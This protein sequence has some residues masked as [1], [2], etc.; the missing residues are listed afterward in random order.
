MRLSASGV[1]FQ[2]PSETSDGSVLLAEVSP[3]AKGFAERSVE[4][5]WFASLRSCRTRL[6]WAWKRGSSWGVGPSCRG[7]FSMP[8]ML[9]RE[10]V[11]SYWSGDPYGWAGWPVIGL[12]AFFCWGLLARDALL[13][14]G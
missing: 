3:D 11:A 10:G 12:G 6:R 8:L 5:A 7:I 13:D 14:G 4:Y 9:L 1:R 2:C